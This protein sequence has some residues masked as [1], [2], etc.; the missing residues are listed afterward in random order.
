M[1]VRIRGAAS[2][3]GD[4]LVAFGATR[5]Y[6]DRF[7][8]GRRGADEDFTGGGNRIAASAHRILGIDF[9]G[10]R[11]A[12]AGEAGVDCIDSESGDAAG[13]SVDEPLVVDINVGGV[14]GIEAPAGRAAQIFGKFGGLGCDAGRGRLGR[15]VADQQGL[16]RVDGAVGAGGAV[17]RKNL[18]APD[19][20]DVFDGHFNL[21]VPLLVLG[22]DSAVRGW[23]PGTSVHAP[24]AVVK[25][26]GIVAV[27][28]HADGAT[29]TEC[30]GVRGIRRSNGNVLRLAWRI[31][32]WLGDGDR[33][34]LHRVA[35]RAP[36][37]LGDDFALPLFARCDDA[38]RQTRRGV[39]GLFDSVLI[40]L[41]DQVDMV[42]VGIRGVIGHAREGVLDGGVVRS[43]FRDGR[44]IGR[45]IFLG[46]L[47]VGNEQRIADHACAD[48]VELLLD[49]VVRAARIAGAVER[50]SLFKIFVQHANFA[51]PERIGVGI[52]VG[53]RDGRIR[54]DGVQIRLSNAVFIPRVFVAQSVTIRI[55]G[56]NGFGLQM[57]F[58]SI[59]IGRL[60]DDDFGWGFRCVIDQCCPVQPQAVD[61]L[62]V[63]AGREALHA[64]GLNDGA[65]RAFEQ[66]DD[67]GVVQVP[68]TFG[69][70]WQLRDVGDASEP[71]SE[72][73][74]AAVK[75]FAHSPMSAVIDLFRED[76]G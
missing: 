54:S 56:A 43:D 36:H 64:G 6:R 1:A 31:A 12:G 26:E 47:A 15:L 76:S 44:G 73:H 7:R 20:A 37:V 70:F 62:I 71:V 40:P 59:G 2:G 35:L 23:A 16:R 74:F 11:L 53:D 65:V 72:F 21:A 38:V 13:F 51:I 27:G 14:L 3:T 29:A 57:R 50:V 46:G 61:N 10:P 8:R 33:C 41:V 25:L 4:D 68:V 22:D 67:P 30:R 34:G 19:S 39:I 69:Q 75:E 24:P 58:A 42:A 18:A 5:A 45:L 32:P 66:G 52:G 49:R 9:A 17:A 60:R 63:G 55:V 48:M 28:N